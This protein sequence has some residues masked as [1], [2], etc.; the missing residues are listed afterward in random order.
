MSRELRRNPGPQGRDEFQRERRMSSE[1]E[2]KE[3]KGKQGDLVSG[4]R[5]QLPWT[6]RAW[7]REGF[8]N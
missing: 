7:L 6:G 8:Q 3:E 4:G 1:M 5:S 2:G